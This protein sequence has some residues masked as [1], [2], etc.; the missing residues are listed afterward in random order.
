MNASYKCFV[1]KQTHN[2]VDLAISHLKKIHFLKDNFDQFTCIKN[3]SC[4]KQFSTI[5]GLRKH[6]KAC[7]KQPDRLIDLP[8]AALQPNPPEEIP[9]DN[10][11][12]PQ[13]INVHFDGDTYIP[14]E[15]KL[16]NNFDNF[17]KSYAHKIVN[18]QLKHNDTNLIFKLTE[19]LINESFK[20][21]TDIKK[22][23][24]ENHAFCS[25]TVIA[26]T[27]ECIKKNIQKYDSKYKRDQ[28]FKKSIF[29]VEP[30]E[31]SIGTRWDNKIGSKGHNVKLIQSTFQ[32][33]SIISSIKSLFAQETF[34]DLYFAYN[35]GGK[36]KCSEGIFRD[37]C[38]AANF[39]KSVFFAKNPDALQLQFFI[40][41]FEPCQETKSK[42]TI[43]KTC[44]IYMRIRNLPSR[45]LSKTD[46]IYLVAVC[47]A[48]DLKQE[49]ID[50][51][52]MLKLF[53]LE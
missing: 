46:N 34:R 19:D 28:H 6:L 16:Y 50:I 33:V 26:D 44:G 4:G 52:H 9:L 11:L 51:N 24:K 23:Q 30:E 40:D 45:F 3:Q 13:E 1:C 29:Y 22:I 43:H 8:N 21:Y 2:N 47:N 41:D 38:C 18:L 25:S 15:N 49:F 14:S 7:G 32:Y 39:K 53:G 27:C 48:N 5:S 12:V 37:F 17:F 42:R 36:H 35:T 20:L 10:N 31:L